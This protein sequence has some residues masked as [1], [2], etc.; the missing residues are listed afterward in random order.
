MGLMDLS[1]NN[2]TTSTPAVVPTPPP[3]GQPVPTAPPAPHKFRTQQELK[4]STIFENE[5]TVSKIKHQVD[6]MRWSVDYFNQI[7]NIN[8]QPMAP[9]INIPSTT[10]KY[11]RIDH[12]DIYV[13]SGLPTGVAADVSGTGVINAG[14][15]PITG[16]A[17]TAT[18]A[19]GRLVMFVLTAVRKEYYNTHDIYA[20]DYKLTYFLDTSAANYN[21]L[22]YKTIRTYAYDRE[23][24]RTDTPPVLLLAD[25]KIKIGL[26]KQP[27][28]ILSHYLDTFYD[29]RRKLLVLPTATSTYIDQLAMK[30]M[31][32]LSSVNDDYRLA[33]LGRPDTIINAI[34]IW[35]AVINQDPNLLVTCTHQLHYSMTTRSTLEPVVAGSYLGINYTITDRP[36]STVSVPDVIPNPLAARKT[37]ADPITP[38][39]DTYIFSND[40]YNNNTAGVLT[41]FESMV[42]NYIHGRLPNTGELTPILNDYM[43][44]SYDR[45]YQ[46]LPILM[47]ITKSVV[48]NTYSPL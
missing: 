27:V 30:A 15:V 22:V 7:L 8:T 20:V 2:P 17:F 42:L 44:W 23:S 21:D 39:T 28:K 13:N 37:V 36:T 31:Y 18:V 12:L 48:N 9:D 19:G 25:Y 47:V 4:T 46:L 41:P 10:L 5:L 14:F 32:R 38:P 24:I 6:G 16:D 34:T 35:D 11:N 45:Q 33:E 29:N 1:N 43:H 26:A 3:S 40:V